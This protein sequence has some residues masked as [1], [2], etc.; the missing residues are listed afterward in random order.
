M[1]DPAGFLDLG[2]SSLRCLY[3]ATEVTFEEDSLKYY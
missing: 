3:I 2:T 1:I